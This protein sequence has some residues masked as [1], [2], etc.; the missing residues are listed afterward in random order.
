MV[1]KQTDSFYESDDEVT[2]PR[3]NKPVTSPR[4]SLDRRKRES[5]GSN[6][7]YENSQVLLDIKN[8]N[9]QKET[10][11]KKFPVPQPRST[12][13][14]HDYVNNMPPENLL[15]LTQEK[16]PADSKSPFESPRSESPADYE[17]TTFALPTYEEATSGDLQPDFFN[18]ND[19]DLP[20][21]APPVPPRSESQEELFIETEQS[22]NHTPPDQPSDFEEVFLFSLTCM[23]IEFDFM[24]FSAFL[25]CMAFCKIKSISFFKISYK[26][27]FWKLLW[28]DM[29]MNTLI[30]VCI[31]MYKMNRTKLN[32]EKDR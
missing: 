29:K 8:S 10:V 18:M 28:N 6:V 27:E 25:Q 16:L 22:L 2:S 7:S 4:R 11:Q 19:L 1:H 21:E 26:K 23:L 30:T 32:R 13:A 24:N 31:S 9:S 17:N 14:L 5:T 20:A 3:K 15:S 12:S